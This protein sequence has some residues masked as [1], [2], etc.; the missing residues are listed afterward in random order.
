M[1]STPLRPKSHSRTDE[2][3]SWSK[4]QR[5]SSSKSDPQRKNDTTQDEKALMDDLMAGLD[6]SMFDA[7]GSSPI[8][9]K[10]NKSSQASPVQSQPKRKHVEVKIEPL[11]PIKKI[12]VSPRK[13]KA[14]RS[15][16]KEKA[17]NAFAPTWTKSP[18]KIKKEK[19][20]S[21][22]KPQVEASV[23]QEIEIGIAQDEPVFKEDIQVKPELADE[24]LYDFDFDLNDLTAFEEELLGLPE[25]KTRYPISNPPRPPPPPGY[26]STPWTRCI[27]NTVSTGL[28]FT[29][30]IIP[31]LDIIEADEGGGTS[32]GKTLIVTSTENEI[33]RIVHLKDQWSNLHIKKNDIVNIISPTLCDQNVVGPI[34]LTL[35]DPLTFLIHHPDLML[36]MTSI[37]NAMPCPRKP[38]LQSLIKT[39]GPPSKAVLYGNLL[40]SLLQGAL[41]EQS[42]DADSTFKRIDS[43]LKKE[44]RRLEIWSTGIGMMDV[45]EE[46]GMRA[47]RGFEVFGDKWVGEQPGTKGE[48]HTSPG[49]NP[50]F[51]AISGLH[52]VEEDIWSPK[53]G[54]KGKVDA[55]VQAK[56]IRD[57]SKSQEA[58]EFVS[59]LEIKTG[60]SVGVMAHRAQ[61]MLYT[62]L[63][64]DRYGVPVPAGLLY[65]SQLDSILR[66]EA[67]QNEIRAL[68]IARNELADWLSKKRRVPKPP[69]SSS[70]DMVKPIED[71]EE[72]F[73][74]PTIDHTKECRSCYAVDS[75]MLYRKAIDDVQPH[76]QDP[77][78]DLYEEKTGHMT[79]KD[80]EF[81]KKW[82][83]LL[84]VEEQDIGRHRSQ[85]WTLTAK[86]RE[87]TGRCFGDMIILSYSNDL[88]KSLAKIHRHAY[89]FIRAPHAGT[90][91]TNT[92]LLSGHIAKGDPVSLSIEPDLLCLSRGFVLDLTA[93][94]ITIGVTYVIDVEALLKRTGR[95]H[96]L[97]E[98]EGKVVFRID[99]DEMASGMMRMRNNLASLFYAK[100]GDGARRRLIVDLAKP[101]FESSWIPHDN[102][103]PAHLNEDQRNAMRKVMSARDYALILGMPG[104]GKTTTIAEIIKLLV[105]EGKSVLLTSFTH[106]AV[107]TILMK[108]LN[109]EFGILRLGNIDKV[110][111]DVQHFTLEAMEQSTSMEQLE[112]RLMNPPV[113]A[114]TCLA[115]DHPLFFK[116]RFD[117]CIVDEASQITLPTCIGPLRMA[118]RFVL[119]GDHFQL[120][121]I[122]RHPEARRGGLDVSLFK[123]LS[124]AHPQSV[125]DLS[126]Q[127]RM[128][129]DIMLLSNRLVYEGKL[130]CGN[131]QVAHRGL[132]LK[133]R[134]E[135]REVFKCEED[136]D[137]G[138][139]WIQDLLEEDAKCIFVDTDGLP[140]PDSR[141]GDL[142][143]NEVE[144]KLVQQLAT[145]LTESGLHQEDLAIITP[146]RQ[147]IKLLSSLVKSSLPRVEILTADKSQGR[148]KDC[149]LISL[150]R[151]N[152]GG[153]IGDLLKDWRRINVSFT[154]AK[155]KLIIFGSAKTL[156]QDTLL[157]DF[158]E[159]M[160]SKNWIKRL[161]RG[162][163]SSHEM[164]D[165]ISTGHIRG[166]LQVKDE[167]KEDEEDTATR[168]R[169]QSKNGKKVIRANSDVLIKGAF[170]TEILVSRLLT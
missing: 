133:G 15:P 5:L 57:P 152:E 84:T 111:P 39:P 130:K 170:G 26:T 125:T 8:R 23:K 103:I 31:S 10:S 82:D 157:N 95:S 62:L 91:A 49:D 154:R 169:K 135:C 159:L 160:K 46:I 146:Y 134:K 101:E 165:H 141:V 126:M 121:P 113:V 21:Q 150:V 71:V 87:K 70:D 118:D 4:R 44:E 96:A 149:I 98:G 37:A 77:I 66:V 13:K 3:H 52:E 145:A 143:Q 43:E 9:P 164:R 104:T 137:H 53:W 110:H 45:R 86:Q 27:V 75:C 34:V 56:I 122:V 33:K 155:K 156:S 151:S 81:Y 108:L 93:K 89:T 136:V 12:N 114:A 51:L 78:A 139:C 129:E 24:D 168:T 92:S 120:P 119:V 85:L 132:V 19:A 116:R 7:I 127:Y 142:V 29:N 72:A 167:V 68:I 64:E 65:Y 41:L 109:T 123:L 138:D 67:K 59:P 90:Q 124:S 58:E 73:L 1:T 20:I 161:D 144:A 40:H 83:T 61:T 97:S 166:D 148:D 2:N 117:Y 100:D 54:L 153:N 14:Q 115:I 112:K 42:F 99:K 128:N 18:A 79:Q 60:R 36:T 94:S 50:S 17:G 80:A 6:A 25:A 140:A 69:T 107:D 88:G 32:Y 28:R 16:I 131:E 105:N 74:P 48:L 158:L 30:G 106:S 76:P 38:I 102:Q 47:G 147:Q 63:M 55:S 35:K 162:D 163:D 22:A 11:S